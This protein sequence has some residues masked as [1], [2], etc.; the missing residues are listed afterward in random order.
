MEYGDGGGLLESFG[1]IFGSFCQ[2]GP[3]KDVVE[4]AGVAILV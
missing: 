2:L 3:F 4:A 1:K